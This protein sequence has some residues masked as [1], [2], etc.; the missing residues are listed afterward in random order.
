MVAGA[1]SGDTLSPRLAPVTTV[2]A[3]DPPP[4]VESARDASAK[5]IYRSGLLGGGG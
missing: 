5:Q 2:Q 4:S 3:G 1:A